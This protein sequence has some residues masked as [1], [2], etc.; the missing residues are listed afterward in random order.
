MSL[1]GLFDTPCTAYYFQEV[2]ITTV[3]IL[4]HYPRKETAENLKLETLVGK[5]G[6]TD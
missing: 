4:H 3:F 2:I 1:K 6:R 5:T